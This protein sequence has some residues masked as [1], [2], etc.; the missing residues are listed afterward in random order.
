MPAATHRSDLRSAR[1]ELHR[2]HAGQRDADEA[3][4]HPDDQLI[5]HRRTDTS[6]GTGASDS[7]VIGNTM[8]TWESVQLSA[9][10][11]AGDRA[12]VLAHAP[13]LV[14]RVA[15]NRRVREPAVAGDGG[16]RASTAIMLRSISGNW[17]P[18]HQATKML[19]VTGTAS[20]SLA[21]D[22]ARCRI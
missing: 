11:D 18:C 16:E 8:P 20:G 17:R 2:Q 13:A 1:Q 5:A 7:G 15:A 21:D 14:A 10:D 22:A 3:G 6:G 12:D 4:G 19:S 9:A